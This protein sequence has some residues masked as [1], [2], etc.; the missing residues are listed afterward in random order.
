VYPPSLGSKFV[1]PHG[2]G[3]HSGSSWN[4][5]YSLG[6][7]ELVY[8]SAQFT[9]T[10]CNIN[11]DNIRKSGIEAGAKPPEKHSE[12]P[13]VQV[14]DSYIAGGKGIGITQDANPRIGHFYST[15]INCTIS[16]INSGRYP[17]RIEEWD[18]GTLG[19]ISDNLC[20]CPANYNLD[21]PVGECNTVSGSVKYGINE[22]KIGGIL[23]NEFCH[24]P[25][26]NC[27]VD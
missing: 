26:I 13:L 11:S 4:N 20:L 1:T 18:G 22:W 16:D 9:V 25:I 14:Y 3:D 17:I 27:T 12:K 10:S 8:K 24:E 23:Q 2:T 15:I 7:P 21:C 5:A 6:T 19:E